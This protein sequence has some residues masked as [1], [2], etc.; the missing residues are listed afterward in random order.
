[1]FNIREWVLM[2]ALPEK[3]ILSIVTKDEEVE[4]RDDDDDGGG[5]RD[6]KEEEEVDDDVNSF[7]V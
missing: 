1:M 6:V 5:G 4:D 7:V 2:I 3:S